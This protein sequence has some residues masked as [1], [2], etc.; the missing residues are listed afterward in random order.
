MGTNYYAITDYCNDCGRGERLHIGKSGRI[1]R[2]YPPC[3]ET[4]GDP[5]QS[6]AAWL[7]WLERHDAVIRDEDGD[8]FTIDELAALWRPDP[9]GAERSNLGWYERFGHDLGDYTD[10]DG[11]HM[12]PREFS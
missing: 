2:A 8:P 5:I 11:Y 1:A 3:E 10:R 7:R 9:N 12:S 4:K 6:W